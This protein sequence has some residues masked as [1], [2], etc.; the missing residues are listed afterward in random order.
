MILLLIMTKRYSD[1]SR[2]AI[3]EKVSISLSCFGVIAVYISPIF[4]VTG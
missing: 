1:D 2:S 3:Q 4:D